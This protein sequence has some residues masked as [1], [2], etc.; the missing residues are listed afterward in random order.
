[1]FG[2]PGPAAAAKST[3][4]WLDADLRSY[5]DIPDAAILHWQTLDADR[6]TILW[7]DPQAPLTYSTTGS[8]EVQADFLGGAIAEGN[9]ACAAHTLVPAALKEGPEMLTWG[10]V[11]LCPAPMTASQR[12][13]HTHACQSVEWLC[14]TQDLPCPTDPPICRPFEPER[15]P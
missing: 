1:L 3:R 12:E 6:G 7:V 11:I 5:V 15:N 9:L 4:L 10:R 2:Y 13:C 14:R 8:Q